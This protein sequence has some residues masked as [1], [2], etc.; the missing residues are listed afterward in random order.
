[1]SGTTVCLLRPGTVDYH[2]AWSWQQDAAQ[3]LRYGVG[4]EALALLRH[5]PVYTLGRRGHPDHILIDAADIASR[6]ADLVEVDRGGD[7]TF[8]GPGQLVGYPILDLRSR[9]LLPGDYVR[10]LEATIIDA[11]DAFGIEGRRS[12]GR[13]GVWVGHDKIAALGVHV[14]GGVTTHGFALNVSTDLSWFDAIIPCG[15]AGTRMTSMAEVTQRMPAMRA[16]EDALTEAFAANFGAS[17]AEEATPGGS[18][19]APWGLRWS[20]NV[21]LHDRTARVGR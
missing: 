4:R 8:H 13:P 5:P 9:D 12:P 16:V 7:V 18:L 11:L 17:L 20:S 3:A 6:G 14:R 10:L 19:P 2:S 15:L 1:M 21:G